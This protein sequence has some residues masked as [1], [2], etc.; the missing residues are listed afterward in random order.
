MSCR[1][2]ECWKADLKDDVHVM[3]AQDME[4]EAVREGSCPA[5]QGG[6]HLLRIVWKPG[7]S[8]STCQMHQAAKL[9][10]SHLR[11]L[12]ALNPMHLFNGLLQT[13]YLKTLGWKDFGQPDTRT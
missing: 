12:A 2:E 7:N 4:V 10:D 9:Q 13:C 8:L 5:T 1:A 6:Q 11:H 3:A